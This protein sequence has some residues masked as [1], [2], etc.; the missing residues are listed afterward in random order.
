MTKFEV[1]NKTDRKIVRDGVIFSKF[2]LI[3][4]ADVDVLE[5]AIRMVDIS[6]N[7]MCN[8]EGKNLMWQKR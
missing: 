5:E 6:P 3:Q 4:I 7:L 2:F 1:I 8:V